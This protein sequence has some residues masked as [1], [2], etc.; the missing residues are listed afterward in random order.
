[1]IVSAAAKV[2]DS[3]IDLEISADADPQIA[4]FYQKAID[5]YQADKHKETIASCQKIL[6]IE[7]RSPAIWNLVGITMGKMDLF[8]EALQFL[9]KAVELSPKYAAAWYN[10]GW[11]LGRKGQVEGAE[12][13]VVKAIELE[14]NRF[15]FHK[16]S[17]ELMEVCFPVAEQVVRRGMALHPDDKTML[18]ALAAIHGHQGRLAICEELLKEFHLGNGVDVEKREVD[19]RGLTF[20]CW[21]PKSAGTFLTEGL[22][23]TLGIGRIGSMFDCG[24]GLFPSIH[25]IP[26]GI[27]ALSGMRGMVGSHA[28]ASPHNLAVLD[29]TG[30]DRVL[31]QVRDPRQSLLS[32]FHHCEGG[33]GFYRNRAIES[34]YPAMSTAERQQWL[35]ENYYPRQIQ[36]IQSWLDYEARQEQGPVKVMITTFEKMRE[37]G[38]ARFLMEAVHFFKPDVK[39]IKV[40]EKSKKTRFRKGR[41][42]EWR[43]VFDAEQKAWMSGHISGVMRERFGWTQ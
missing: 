27:A 41:T 34:R 7:P 28:Q 5:S 13:A 40:P 42:S 8:E 2:T 33:L 15:D 36:W 30:V 4:D 6:A 17:V 10:M 37:V 11:I 43:E 23:Q 12:K 20:F 14:P 32:F 16:A 26:S 31:I 19:G 25:L 22:C 24:D 9:N 18:V 3:V 21:L 29:R 39:M 1:M 35:M 38:E